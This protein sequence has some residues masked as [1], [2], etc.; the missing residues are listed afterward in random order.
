MYLSD[1]QVC[2]LIKYSIIYILPKKIIDDK[3]KIVDYIFNLKEA[4]P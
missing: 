2:I 3:K 4:P 1:I